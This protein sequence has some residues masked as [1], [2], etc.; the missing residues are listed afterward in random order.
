MGHKNPCQPGE[1]LDQSVKTQNE[2][3]IF[4]EK[5]I[6]Y[7]P[8]YCAPSGCTSVPEKLG[9]EELGVAKLGVVYEIL[10]A[11]IAQVD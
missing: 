1:K 4:P 2:A 11:H 3:H 9:I 10:N 5:W 6:P 7:H 8:A